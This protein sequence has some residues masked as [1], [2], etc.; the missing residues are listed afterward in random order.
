M[1]LFSIIVIV[2]LG[3]IAFGFVWSLCVVGARDDARIDDL[4]DEASVSDWLGTAVAAASS[5]A[6]LNDLDEASE[7]AALVR[8]RVADWN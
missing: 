8:N 7:Q 1:T 5:A 3:L 2:A 4:L 6:A